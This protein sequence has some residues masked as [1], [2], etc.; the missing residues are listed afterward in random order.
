MSSHH[1]VKEGQEPALAIL[2]PISYQVSDLLEWAPLIVISDS[3][4]EQA[5]QWGIKTDVII[6]EP[7]SEPDIVEKLQH[8]HPL[9]IIS[10]MPQ[11]S[12]LTVL[13]EYLSRHGQTSVNICINSPLVSFDEFELVA[14]KIDISIIDPNIKWSL[15]PSGNLKKWL[16]KDSVIYAHANESIDIQGAAAQPGDSRIVM[17][18]DGILTLETGGLLWFGEPHE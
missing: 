17:Q 4:I 7:Q 10:K 13:M 15:I 18:K 8:Q 6:T 5:I 3:V 12:Q 11:E 14:G 1:F 2:E 9:E 16:K